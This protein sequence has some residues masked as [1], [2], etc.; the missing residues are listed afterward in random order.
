MTSAATTTT[1]KHDNQ[2]TQDQ[3]ESAQSNPPFWCSVCNLD[4][5][6]QA[7]L[8][9]H[10]QGRKH[11]KRSLRQGLPVTNTTKR[12]PFTSSLPQIDDEDELFEGLATGRY[13]NVV[14]LTGAGVST[15]AGI[16]DY[17]STPHGLFARFQRQFGTRF[18]QVHNHPEY[19]LTRSFYNAHT[20]FWQREIWPLARTD[21]DGIMPT[22]THKFCAWLE[23]QDILK[24]IY[25]QNVDGL[26]LHPT[27]LQQVPTLEQK[28]IECHGSLPQGNLVLYEDLLPEIFEEACDQD[29]GAAAATAPVDLLMVFGT[30][31]Q[32]APFC[33]VPNLAPKGCT[34]VLVNRN[35][36]ECLEND[37]SR[38]PPSWGEA[39]GF[40]GLSISSTVQI[41]SRKSVSKRPQ[42]T[43]K[44]GRKK[45]SQLLVEDDCDDFC[46]RFFA[47]AACQ[48]RGYSL[49][50]FEDGD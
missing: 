25:T 11:R 47:H 15:A 21:L 33:A 14:I 16:P 32:V 29:F 34:R 6:S 28:V 8:E 27:L 5:Q 9:E 42:W 18:P 4:L 10:C 45:W 1:A 35:L 24:R 49:R 12:P 3:G 48:E 46:Q 22:N 23:Q 36:E 17:R 38:R 43:G 50:A 44:E 39:A 13:R 7:S 31:L 19:L 37:F 40:G 20:E 26:H 41:G 2:S 30:S